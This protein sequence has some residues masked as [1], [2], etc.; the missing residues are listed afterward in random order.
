MRLILVFG[1]VLAMS[2]ALFGSSAQAGP[3]RLDYA[4]TDLG[5]GVYDYDFQLTLDDNDS[6][7][8]SGQGWG[9]LIFG[10][11]P[12]APSPL[13]GFVIDAATL[14]VGPWTGLSSSSG[15]HNGPTFS[16]VLAY[17]IPTAVGQSLTWSGTST[18]DL[19]QGSL[20]FTTIRVTGGASS[21][22]FKVANRLA[23]AVV[24]EPSTFLL[25]GI[26]GLG[27]AVVARRRKKS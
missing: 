13:T 2:A 7:W 14:P 22:T 10:D 5:G 23:P 17:W 16:S 8:A 27:L 18:A 9:W 19:A 21:E 20:L 3:L 1:V 12:T 25:L 24:P 15:G 6:S 26:G 4:V 11:S